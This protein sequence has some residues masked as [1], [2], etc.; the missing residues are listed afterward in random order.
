MTGPGEG[1]NEGDLQQGMGAIPREGGTTFRVW[2]PHADSVSVVGDFN[3]R[4]TEAHPLWA[5]EDGYWAAYVEAA[6]P[7]DEYTYRIIS[8]D[9]TLERIDPYA[10]EV[11]HS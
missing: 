11:T 2:A 8:G 7:G 5:E 10:R 3:D 9:Q 1:E 6:R 4:S